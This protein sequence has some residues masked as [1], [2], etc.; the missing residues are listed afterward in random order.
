[1]KALKIGIAVVLLA[2]ALAITVLSGDGVDPLADT[3]ESSVKWRCT[4]CEHTFDLSALKSAEAQT[5]AQATAPIHC[6]ECEEKAAYQ[7]IACPDCGTLYFGS[8][9]PGSTGQCPKC[10]PDASPWE[11][12]GGFNREDEMPEIPDAPPPK[13]R[14]KN[15]RGPTRKECDSA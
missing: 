5:R 3:A 2:A 12:G 4:E 15:V 8:E 13:P 10:N 7:V 6:T 9:A 11:P 1:M 14:P